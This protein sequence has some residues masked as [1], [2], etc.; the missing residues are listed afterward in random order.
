MRK[1]EKNRG[2]WTKA[3]AV[4]LRPL[5]DSITAQRGGLPS[6]TNPQYRA[7]AKRAKIDPQARM[8]LTEYLT[9]IHT[10]PRDVMDL[11]V[12]HPA[13]GPVFSGSGNDRATFVAMPGK[14][15]RVELKQLARRAAT[16][17]AKRGDELAAAEIDR[18]LALSAEGRLPGYGVIVIRGL[19]MDGT[20]ELGAGAKLASYE[21][22]VEL[23]LLKKPEPP[24]LNDDP[25][26]KGM[27]A[28]VLFREMTWRPCLVPPKTSKN[29][30][31]PPPE[32]KFTL[33]PELTQSVLLD[34]LSLVTSHRIDVVEMF[35]CAP[36]FVDVD[37][38]FGPGSKIGF[39]QTALLETK[40]PSAHDLAE[41]HDLLFNWTRLDGDL[42]DRL[43]LALPRLVS[44]VQR[45]RNRFWLEDRIIDVA[46]ALEVLYGGKT[47]L[48][49]ARRAAGLLETCTREQISTFKQ[50]KRFYRIR[51]E[52][53]HLTHPTPL[54]MALEKELE[55]GRNLANRTLVT[56]L[57]REKLVQWNKVMRKLQPGALKHIDAE[58][59]Q[60]S[61]KS[62][63]APADSLQSRGEPS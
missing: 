17:G 41:A 35:S 32:P 62:T 18:F 7:L 24:P 57:K 37:P 49:L 2:D 47:G 38:K 12:K 8:V 13:V 30:N 55:V 29:I 11:V 16:I 4:A 5:S 27:E 60:P 58:K 33:A 14:G 39:S 10:D 61:I 53:V 63:D 46:I 59:S 31:D 42:R 28:L 51:S 25:D 44:A 23:G 54:R 36:E 40:K 20:V 15:F 45:D 6:L 1:M 22:A 9:D 19:S 50:A 52:I 56:L 34:L 26:Y 48:K 3:F 43:E 21:S